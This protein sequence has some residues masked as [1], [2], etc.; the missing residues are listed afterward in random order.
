MT[1]SWSRELFFVLPAFVLALALL[2]MPLA[3]AAEHA[4]VVLALSGKVDL[5]RGGKTLAAA[6]RSEFFSGDTIAVGDG[7]VQLGFADGTLLTLYRNT[8]FAVDDYR[9][10]KGNGDRAQF[11]LVNGLMHT[12]TGKIDKKNYSLKT[13][14]ANLGVRGTDYSARLDETLSVNVNSGRVAISNAAG[15]LLVDAGGSAVVTSVNAMPTPGG[16]KIDLHGADRGPAGPAGPAGVGSGGAAAPPP[17]PPPAGSQ[18]FTGPQPTHQPTTP[19]PGPGA[20][21]G[22]AGPGPGMGGP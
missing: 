1:K 14:L 21:P 3:V 2:P 7:Q 10:A 12:L 5:E 20:G 6:R 15:T 8:R 13:R 11:S 19:P 9:Y 17:P 22:A 18:N 16:G 4:G